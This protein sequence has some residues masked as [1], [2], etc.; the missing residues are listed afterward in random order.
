MKERINMKNLGLIATGGAVVC[1]VGCATPAQF[2]VS[3]PVGPAP[4]ERARAPDEATLQVYSARVRAPVDVNREEFLW[5]ND[6]GK[7][8]FLYEPAHTD[9]TIYCQNGKI[10]KH[11]R[12]A[13][14]AD[15]SQ[16][17]L[18]SMPPGR[19]EVVAS[20]RGFGLVTIPVVI[21]KGKRT[22]VNL[23]RTPNEV[24]A[25]VP[26]AEAVYLAGDRIIGWRA[27]LAEHAANVN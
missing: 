15:D 22:T 12:N 11:V 24:V 5:H 17:A 19:Y 25:V 20:A 8:D 1:L 9:Y 18:M 26:K 10:F 16:P 27:S 14:G 2:T 23:Q 21:E 3:E 6:F 7:N 4:T 13:R